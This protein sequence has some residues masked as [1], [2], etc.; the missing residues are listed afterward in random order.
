M[1][2]GMLSDL[3]YPFVC[4]PI[5]P[6]LFD[7]YVDQL[8]YHSQRS[9]YSLPSTRQFGASCSLSDARLQVPANQIRLVAPDFSPSFIALAIGTQNHT[10]NAT[11][12]V[13]SFRTS[14]H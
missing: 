4:H 7:D 8:A 9:V 11:P 3:T 14:I 13:R 12:H 1:F 5:H 6:I 2:G 10:C